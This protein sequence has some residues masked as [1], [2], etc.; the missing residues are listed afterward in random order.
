[1]RLQASVKQKHFWHMGIANLLPPET[2]VDLEIL[3]TMLHM[4]FFRHKPLRRQDPFD[5][6]P[7]GR[8]V[9]DGQAA[10]GM[11]RPGCR[12]KKDREPMP[13]EHFFSLHDPVN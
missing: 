7:V 8:G 10:V 4:D 3:L 13:L 9:P 2:L 11:E 1:M 5:G 6:L 12:D